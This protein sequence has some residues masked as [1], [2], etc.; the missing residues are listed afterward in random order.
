GFQ[1][2]LVLLA[3]LGTGESTSSTTGRTTTL[4]EGFKPNTKGTV[5]Q[6]FIEN[7]LHPSLKYFYD[8]AYAGE[9][10]PFHVLDRSVQLAIPMITKD[11]F[12]LAQEEPH[13]VPFLAP[14][15]SGGMGSQ[16]YT[17]K[18]FGKPEW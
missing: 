16:F 9:G 8:A 6:R 17:G 11:L 12:E 4:G 1:Q 18:D 14:L 3:R 2:F 15:I 5:A 13:L 7:K 10:K